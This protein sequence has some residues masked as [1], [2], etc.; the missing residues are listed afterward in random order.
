MRLVPYLPDAPAPAALVAP[1][2]ARVFRERLVE[3]FERHVRTDSASDRAARTVPTTAMQREFAAVLADDLRGLG[4]VGVAVDEWANV[5]GRL[6]GTA[7]GRPLFYS[8]HLDVV[9]A[10][11]CTGIVPVRHE[12]VGGDL[13]V[14]AERGLMIAAERLTA[15]VGDLLV[16]SDGRTLL[17]ADDKLGV[18]EVLHALRALRVQ[19][20]PHP[21]I[22]VTFYSD[23][24]TGL[25]G[26]KRF[27]L[28]ALLGDLPLDAVLAVETEIPEAGKILVEIC[29][30]SGD[31]VSSG[32]LA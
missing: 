28:A 23:E 17:G 9:D 14:S 19:G 29:S 16:T 8:A 6:P 27:D 10:A 26:A 11:P 1:L 15:Y 12:Y 22:Y 21:D 32:M 5:S 25:Q 20:V 2:E 31:S 24:E 7:P 4:C 30:Q 13:V 18:T 3:T